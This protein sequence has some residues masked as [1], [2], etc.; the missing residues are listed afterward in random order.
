MTVLNPGA[1]AQH[2]PHTCDT[3][4]LY[5]MDCAEFEALRARAAGRCEMCGIHEEETPLGKLAVDHA[6]EYG[7]TAVRGLVCSQCNSVLGVA[8]SRMTFVQRLYAKDADGEL[9]IANYLRRAWFIQVAEWARAADGLFGFPDFPD[10]RY[11]ETM[12]RRPVVARLR[13][14][15]GVEPTV[16]LECTIGRGVVLVSL[17]AEFVTADGYT[18]TA[19]VERRPGRAYSPARTRVTGPG[20]DGGRR[21]FGA[22]PV[23]RL[24]KRAQAVTR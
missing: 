6:H 12:L 17:V 8:E 16:T 9:W 18:V 22:V 14:G 7:P 19:V 11:R 23:L 1:D 21:H 15:L 4:R 24:I 20:V 2:G 10:Q 3:H 5:G 13:A